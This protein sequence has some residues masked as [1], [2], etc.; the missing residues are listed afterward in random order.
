MNYR[1]CFNAGVV[2][3][4]FPEILNGASLS[5]VASAR[6]QRNTLLNAQEVLQENWFTITPDSAGLAEID[7]VILGYVETKNT[8]QS[9]LDQGWSLKFTSSVENYETK[10]FLIVKEG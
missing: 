1:E 6:L 10:V 7:C 8:L 9:F 5:E 3:S 2:Y 4:V